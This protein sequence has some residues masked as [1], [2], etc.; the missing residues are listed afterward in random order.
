MAARRS[1]NWGKYLGVVLSW[2][3]LQLMFAETM[4][5]IGFPDCPRINCTVCC[6]YSNIVFGNVNNWPAETRG[7][8]E[9]LQTGIFKIWTMGAT[10]IYRKWGVTLGEFLGAMDPLISFVHC[11][12]TLFTT[13]LS[14]FKNWLCPRPPQYPL[15]PQPY[16]SSPVRKI[17]CKMTV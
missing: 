4:M 14:N 9:N 12:W 8:M 15:A 2:T 10:L 13:K 1:V 7:W 6:E 3:I 16:Y 11:Y 17:P 5:R